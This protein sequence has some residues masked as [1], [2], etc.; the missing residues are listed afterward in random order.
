MNWEQV[1][2]SWRIL[3]GKAKEQWAKLTDDDL[4][5]VDGHHDQLIGR[6]QKRYG[7]AREEAERAVH[8]W[9][10]TVRV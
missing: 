6:I 8:D 10:Q 7:M 1:A 2:G 4:A 3:R 5:I 9:L